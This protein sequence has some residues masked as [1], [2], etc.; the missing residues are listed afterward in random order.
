MGHHAIRAVIDDPIDPEKATSEAERESVINYWRLQ[1][2]TR[3]MPPDSAACVLIMQRI[4][5]R[6]LTGY[7]LADETGWEHLCLPME[8]PT[9]S[10]FVFRS[11][12]KV[13]RQAGEL[14]CPQR[15]GPEAVARLK[16]S[17]GSYGASGQ[18][19]QSPS[20]EGGGMLK[21]EWWQFYE[22]RPAEFDEVIQSWDCTFK[23]TKDSDYVV[24]QVWGKKGGMFYLLDQ[25]RD[26]MDFPATVRAIEM[27]SAKW[28]GSVAKLVEDKANG[29]AVISTLR[30]KIPGLIAVEP[31]GSKQARAS[32]VSPAIEAKNVW[33]PSPTL[34][35]WIGDFVEECS[36]FDRGAHDDQVDAMTQALDRFLN[37]VSGIEEFYSR[38]AK[39]QA[40]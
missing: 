11:G 10:T 14:L 23:E 28:P 17:L 20:P 39:E 2:S 16:L 13:E 34:A 32:A 36:A 4:H 40:A 27:L 19:Q 9:R 26:R 37:S 30:S 31:R 21:R 5:E 12:R 15:F 22:M 6:D 1:L 33:L 3:L 25:V 35:S 29:P 18:L 38:R 8:A 24:G 7:L